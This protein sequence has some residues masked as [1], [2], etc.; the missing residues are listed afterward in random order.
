MILRNAFSIF[1]LR[2]MSSGHFYLKEKE[3]QMGSVLFASFCSFGAK[4]SKQ[5]FLRHFQFVAIIQLE[6][7]NININ[8]KISK[9]TAM[10]K[11]GKRSKRNAVMK[12]VDERKCGMINILLDIANR[13]VALII[14]LSLPLQSLLSMKSY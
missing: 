6:Y 3:I 11:K 8:C 1:C 9:V 5:F 4:V 12:Q 14:K 2:K 13:L 10:G 7:T